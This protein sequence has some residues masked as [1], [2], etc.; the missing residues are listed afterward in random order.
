MCVVDEVIEFRV[1][2]FLHPDFFYFVISK[3]VVLM[4]ICF[5]EKFKVIYRNIFRLIL[6]LQISDQLI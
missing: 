2:D 5:S 3:C 4:K 6:L 1:E